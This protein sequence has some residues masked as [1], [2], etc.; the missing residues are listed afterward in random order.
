MALDSIKFRE[1]C[2]YRVLNW[3][4]RFLDDVNFE[5]MAAIA[6]DSEILLNFFFD[7]NFFI[8]F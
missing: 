1:K 2:T 4:I 3:K 5:E 7:R 6:T 8:A